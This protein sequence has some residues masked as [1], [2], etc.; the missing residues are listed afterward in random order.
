MNYK[1]DQAN[2]F[3]PFT[4][5]GTFYKNIDDQKVPKNLDR[6]IKFWDIL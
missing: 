2:I 6:I 1:D 5:F 4:K 3:Y